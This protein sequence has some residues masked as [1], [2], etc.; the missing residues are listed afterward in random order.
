MVSCGVFVVKLWWIA[1]QSWRDFGRCGAAK[2][3]PRFENISVEIP[4]AEELAEGP[5]DC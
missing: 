1:W 4:H 3:M 2:Y 5:L